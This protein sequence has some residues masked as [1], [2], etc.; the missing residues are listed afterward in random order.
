E[1]VILAQGQLVLTHVDCGFL[2][3]FPAFH[4]LPPSV[5]ERLICASRN[6]GDKANFIPF[7]KKLIIG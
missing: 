6:D 5:C 2:V 7:L 4:R 1:E 3:A